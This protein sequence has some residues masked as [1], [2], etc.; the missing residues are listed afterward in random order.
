MKGV[1]ASKL[2]HSNSGVPAT[3]K[4]HLKRVDSETGEE[5]QDALT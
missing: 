1:P 2:L 5:F 4:E 3:P